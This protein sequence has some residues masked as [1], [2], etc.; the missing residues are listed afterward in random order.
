M[1]E[2]TSSFFSRVNV[3]SFLFLS[4]PYVYD[5][6]NYYAHNFSIREFSFSLPVFFLLWFFLTKF[7]LQKALKEKGIDV[8]VERARQDNS[9]NDDYHMKR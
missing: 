3:P 8:M 6:T 1:L 4:T 2:T 9:A 5:R 7:P